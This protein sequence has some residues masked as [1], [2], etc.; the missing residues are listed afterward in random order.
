MVLLAAVTSVRHAVKIA[1]VVS[2]IVLLSASVSLAQD[3]TWK[4]R[5]LA[6]REPDRAISGCSRLLAR[7]ISRVH[8]EAFHNRNLAA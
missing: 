1:S 5:E 6:D 2:L 8:A 7:P 3:R 4:D